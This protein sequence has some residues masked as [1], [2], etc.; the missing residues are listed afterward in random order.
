M[1]LGS[2]QGLTWPTEGVD[3]QRKNFQITVNGATHPVVKHAWNAAVRETEKIARETA[4]AHAEVL[5]LVESQTHKLGFDCVSGI[6]TWEG[7]TVHLVME[8]R[9]CAKPS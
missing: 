6:R 4:R 9:L 3:V 5:E 7:P 1:E 8:I 2:N